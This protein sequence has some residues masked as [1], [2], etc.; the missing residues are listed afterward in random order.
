MDFSNLDASDRQMFVAQVAALACSGGASGTH[1]PHILI[2]RA[3]TIANELA[4]ALAA[5]AAGKDEAAIVA[6]RRTGRQPR[7]SG[8][9][10][11]GHVADE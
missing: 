2:E 11:T 1:Q 5:D 7:P 3:M 4:D 8:P 10:P 6:N 9:K